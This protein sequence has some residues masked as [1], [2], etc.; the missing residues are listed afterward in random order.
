V[1]QAAIDATGPVQNPTTARLLASLSLER[2]FGDDQEGRLRLADEALALAR[3]LGDPEALA[4]VLLSRFWVVWTPDA[5]DEQRAIVGELLDLAQR[6][7][8]PLHTTQ[9]W[10]LRYLIQIQS[11]DIEAAERSL[12]TFGHLAEELGHASPRFFA[13]LSRCCF[14]LMSGRIGEAERLAGT[15]LELGRTSGQPDVE[16]LFSSVLFSIRY[17]Q[18]RVGEAE[19][20]LAQVSDATPRYALAP[21]R[22]AVT[23]CELDRLVDAAALLESAARGD[24]R[25]VRRDWSWL[26]VLSLWSEVAA[27]LGDATRARTLHGLLAPY[28]DRLVTVGVRPE[29]SVAH[30]LGLLTTAFSRYSDADAH[31]TAAE[32]MHR[33]VD[34]PC[35]LARTRMEWAGMLLQRSRLGDA[36][37]ARVLLREALAAASQ[38][39]LGAVERRSRALLESGVAVATRHD[40]SPA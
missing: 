21:A 28:A 26:G 39:G 38:L 6:L 37:R 9:T 36:E 18:G 27:H 10:F 35:W 8:D 12:E 5:L 7:A 2:M 11:A 19:T 40:T 24:F 16:T 14:I 29:M 20:L 17:V 22:L 3:G 1:L 33:R 25:Q 4:E 13:C 15:M 30:Y 23:Y 31:F 34:A 32:A